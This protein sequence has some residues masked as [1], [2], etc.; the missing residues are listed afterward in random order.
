MDV[1]NVK[2]Y[3]GKKVLLILKNSFQ[4]SCTIPEFY[5]DSFEVY[6]KYGRRVEVACDYVAL[7][8]E[9]EQ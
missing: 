5:G 8:K 6:D 4:Y 3:V 7:I 2:K 1:I 9:D